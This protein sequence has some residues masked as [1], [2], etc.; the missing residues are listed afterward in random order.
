MDRRFV[1]NLEP[2]NDNLPDLENKMRFISEFSVFALEGIGD[3]L[4]PSNIT[5]GRDEKTS[6]NKFQRKEITSQIS[7]KLDEVYNKMGANVDKTLIKEKIKK[8]EEQ[9]KILSDYSVFQDQIRRGDRVQKNRSIEMKK[10]Y[11]HA[12]SNLRFIIAAYLGS[13]NISDE[14]YDDFHTK[15]NN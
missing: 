12:I 15:I 2:A 13:Y 14:Q 1:E 11:D 6:T 8:I 4:H 9:L 10:I 3:F 7:Q 5:I